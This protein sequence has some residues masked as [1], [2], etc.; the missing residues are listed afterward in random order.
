M[1]LMIEHYLKYLESQ[2]Y[3]ICTLN[4]VRVAGNNYATTRR[5]KDDYEF[6]D[7]FSAWK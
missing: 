5:K 1:N 3:T 7:I 6:L 2:R 4:N